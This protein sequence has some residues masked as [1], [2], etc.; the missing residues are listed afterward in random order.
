MN[1]MIQHEDGS[2]LN[3]DG[4]VYHFSKVRFLEEVCTGKVCFICGRGK[5]TTEVSKEH[6]IPKWILKKYSL[7]NRNLTLL[8]DGRSRRYDQQVVP[9]CSSCNSLMGK[10]LEEPIRNA[11]VKGHSGVDALIKTNHGMKLVYTWLALIFFKLTL[12]SLET[13]FSLD[14]RVSTSKLSNM[15]EWDELY[16]VHT[17]A[18][19]FFSNAEWDQGV[20]GSVMIFPAINDERCESF[21]FQDFVNQQSL[22]LRLDD[23]CFICVFNDSCG[24][25]SLFMDKSSI[26]KA[27]LGALSPIQYRE[28]LAHLTYLSS[29]L[30]QHPK[31]TYSVSS[32]GGLTISADHPQNCE[33]GEEPFESLGQLLE[34]CCG[35]YV[36]PNDVQTRRLMR[37]GS[38]SFILD[39]NGN[40]NSRVDA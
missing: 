34:L 37:E 1:S 21:D 40:F 39:E 12:K 4:S 26:M 14:Q 27:K 38:C 3:T 15:I 13:T 25:S 16:H 33:I 18:R 30:L 17:V 36:D 35:S 23:V 22:M 7:F 10:W 28:I 8:H 19:S 24:S 29:V 2:W 32:S 11:L 20:A 9:C 31:F 6:I 5:N